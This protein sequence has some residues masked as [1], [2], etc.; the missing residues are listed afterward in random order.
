M[1]NYL[2]CDDGLKFL[3]ACCVKVRKNTEGNKPV[4]GNL[5]VERKT[6]CGAKAS[7]VRFIGKGRNKKYENFFSQNSKHVLLERKKVL[8][9]QLQL[10]MSRQ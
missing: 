1:H 9:C 8:N 3:I 5:V 7:L 2:S 4:C 10:I 6:R